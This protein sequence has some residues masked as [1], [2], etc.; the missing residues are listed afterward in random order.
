MR[1]ITPL[2][3]VLEH[4]GRRQDWAARQAGYSRPYVNRLARGITPMNPRAARRL[5]AV[6]GVPPDVLLPAD[7][8]SEVTPDAIEVG[9]VAV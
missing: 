4:Q 3:R 9:H 7:A 1:D 6:L 8:V 5:G 2:A